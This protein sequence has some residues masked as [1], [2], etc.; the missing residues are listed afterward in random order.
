MTDRALLARL[1][2]YG[3]TTAEIHYYRPDYPS[4]LQLFV[5]QDYDLPP[6]FPVL[7][8][9]LGLWRRQIEAALHSVRI[10]HDALIGPAEWRAADIIRSLD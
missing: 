2:G 1:D 3:L 6:D 5:W 7:F 9:F 10:A 4:L 8:D